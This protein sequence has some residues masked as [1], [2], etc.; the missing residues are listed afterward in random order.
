M[1]F[2]GQPEFSYYF[3][4]IV[5]QEVTGQ[6][7]AFA[8]R[9][10]DSRKRSGYSQKDFAEKI[11]MHQV[12][13]GR[14]ERGES[15]PYAETLGKIAEALKVS[16]D[17]L[18]DG[19]EDSAVVAKFADRELLKMFEEVEKFPVAEKEHI[20]YMLGTAIRSKKHEAVSAAS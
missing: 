4:A 15:I 10:R 3:T 7:Q 17:Y 20:K 1:F 19:K 16:V 2:N 9:L 8:T 13:Y 14:Y 12:Q 6:A 11:E 5:A 18:L